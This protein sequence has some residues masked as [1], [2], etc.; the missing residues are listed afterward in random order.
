MS[1]IPYSYDV[2]SMQA[3]MLFHSLYSGQTGVYVQQ[4]VAT[5]DHELDS[6]AF[7]RAWSKVVERHDIFRTSFHWGDD[8]KLFQ[9]VHRTVELHFLQEDWR[10]LAVSEQ[11]RRLESYLEKDK[12]D[13]FELGEP[14]LMRLALFALGNN[15]H[16]L[17]WTNHHAL[18]DGRSRVLVIKELF[19]IYESLVGRRDIELNPA[20][21]Y[22]D[23]VNWL[24]ALDL[25]K[26]EE[27]WRSL[28]DGFVMPTPLPGANFPGQL[29][30][31][32]MH[33]EK[34]ICL[35]EELTSRLV[36]IAKENEITLNTLLQGAWAMLL[37][38]FS[39]TDDVVFG[40]TRA[41]RRS[42]LEGAESM[43]GLFINTVPVRVRIRPEVRLSTWLRELRAQHIAVRDYEHTPLVSISGWTRVAGGASLFESIV[44]FENH[45]F[46]AGMKAQGGEWENRSFQLFQRSNYPITLVA[47][48][49]RELL[50]RLEYDRCSV[51]EQV[52][53]RLSNQLRRTLQLFAE[54]PAR[55]LDELE[56][57]SSGERHQIFVE[58]NDTAVDYP[59]RMLFHELFEEQARLTPDAV[60]VV[61]KE[62]NLTYSQLNERA[63]RLAHY[64]IDSGAGPEV[65]V[66]VCLH[67]SIE[68]VVSVVAVLK[69]G[70]AYLPLDP[71][72][73]DQR[74][75]LMLKHANSKLLLTKGSIERELGQQAIQIVDIEE[76]ANKISSRS[77]GNPVRRADPQNLAYVI[78]TSGSTGIPRGAMI[79]HRSVVNLLTILKE[80]IYANAPKRPLRISLNGS[81]AFDTSVKQLIQL[82]SGHAIHV[83][84][85]EVRKDPETLMSFVSSGSL[86]V[87][88]CTPST[89][90][91]LID[92]GL[93]QQERL[94]SIILVGGEAIDG[95]LWQLLA[96]SKTTDVYNVYGPTETTVNATACCIELSLKSPV[97]GKPLGNIAVYVLNERLNPVEKGAVGELFIAG[98]AVGRGY[99]G[100]PEHTAERFLPDQYS[101]GEGDR[102]YRTGDFCR[103][104][105]D[106]RLE[107]LGRRDEQVKLRGYRVEP[108][109]VEA[110][111]RR[112]KG[113]KQAAVLVKEAPTG[114]KMLVGY[115]VAEEGVSGRHVRECVRRE[116]PEYMAPQTVVV[117]EEMPMS[118]NGKLDRKKLQSLREA[119]RGKE[120]A[121]R[122]RPATAA[123]EII[124]GIW[125]EV[126]KRESV[127]VT[128]NFFDLGGHSLLATQVIVRVRKAFGVEIALSRLFEKATVEGLAQA[129]EQITSSGTGS[130]IPTI[131]RV[132]RLGLVAAKTQK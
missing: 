15:C 69:S 58:C 68:L 65:I 16:K 107:Y 108:G 90:Q 87:L 111:L 117:I 85:E 12:T 42:A 35:P 33:S 110:A 95:K 43:I 19:A 70:S 41:C 93:L 109:E 127:E 123:E 119:E 11:A 63:N 17:V 2:S 98:A 131:R 46:D 44:V 4:M 76:Q 132:P 121:V 86:D 25:S 47:Y 112:Q 79:C 115:I 92:C 129:V 96:S 3:G 60:A 66:A 27:F 36:S 130:S 120:V 24:K 81:V 97:I 50:V 71:S 9:T 52:A 55:R 101:S 22:Y 118:A 31:N 1:D 89:L 125:Q 80:S 124:A 64:L 75:A 73:P 84:S 103:Y 78:Y 40:A 126:L 10:G 37:G 99:I 72:Y 6:A 83:V 102:M 62:E 53:V 14:P 54:D 38:A 39:G 29:N 48:R 91:V 61:W 104:K 106:W 30:T 8:G 105:E 7:L 94:P 114:S 20:R 100:R 77:A 57:L 82:A 49:D 116:L 13:G 28:L 113:V 122:E 56:M 51:D 23:Y 59:S 128:Q 88:D 21:P 34:L 45:S 74:L 26:A 5:L 67:R 18:L 32:G